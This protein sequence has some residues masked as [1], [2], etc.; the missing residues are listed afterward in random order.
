[1]NTTCFMAKKS[2]IRIS[3]KLHFIW[4]K[5]FHSMILYMIYFAFYKISHTIKKIS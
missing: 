3:Y 2:Y 5:Y 4:N 1:M